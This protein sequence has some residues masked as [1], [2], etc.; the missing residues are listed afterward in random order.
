MDEQT[1]KSVAAQL[2]KPQGEWAEQIGEFM[3][4]GN[5]LLIERTITATAVSDGERVLE[6][7]MGNG[8]H[9]PAMLEGN[10][11]AYTGYDYSE[12]MIGLA[13]GMNKD[14]VENGRA[15]F[16]CGDACKMPFD[17]NSYDKIF[18]VNTVYFWDDARA[19]CSEIKRVLKPEG[20]LI[21][22]LR[23]ERLMETY[24]MTKWGF[25]LYTAERVKELLAGHGFEVHSVKEEDEPA[26]EVDGEMLQ[27][28]SVVVVAVPV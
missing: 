23:P 8:T 14:A 20:K 11:V 15:E 6:I 22:G 25:T 24:P 26:Q 3:S 4:R 1:A 2:R 7:G 28:A 19:I 16:I 27:L 10:E 17:D 21:L 13:G 9:I 12:D 18:T 5:K